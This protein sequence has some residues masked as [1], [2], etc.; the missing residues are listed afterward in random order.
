MACKLT[1]LKVDLRVAR[2]KRTAC[3]SRQDT[4]AQRSRA[5]RVGHAAE[6]QDRPYCLSVA[7][8]QFHRQRRTIPV[9]CAIAGQHVAEK[10]GAT[11]FDI[12][13]VFWSHRDERCTFDIMIE[14]FSLQTEP[15]LQLANIVRG[16]DTNR[17][18]LAP[19]AA[20]LPAAS[21]GLSQIY[22]DDLEQLDAGMTLYDAFYRWARDASDEG[23]NWPSALNAS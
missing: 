7:D 2:R 22:D 1:A 12:E 19:E 18:D 9:R 10:F 5:Y 14:E 20:G 4:R 16:A 17:H 11:P 3:S 6:A 15:L 8:P 23:H 21:L 13:D